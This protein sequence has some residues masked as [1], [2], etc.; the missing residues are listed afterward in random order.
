M[1]KQFSLNSMFWDIHG[2]C[3]DQVGGFGLCPLGWIILKA[4]DNF[5]YTNL[6]V[7]QSQER[8]TFT[9]MICVF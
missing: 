9:T 2:D 8:I 6:R 3:S 7:S 5:Y 4:S 1:D